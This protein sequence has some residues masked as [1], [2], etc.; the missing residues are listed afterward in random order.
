MDRYA[1][2]KAK[3]SVKCLKKSKSKMHIVSSNTQFRTLLRTLLVRRYQK[4]LL[5][6]VS[7]YTTT[8]I[9]SL[10]TFIFEVW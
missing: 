7:N 3:A 1:K 6:K 5:K 2:V 10:S 4:L 8:P 9:K